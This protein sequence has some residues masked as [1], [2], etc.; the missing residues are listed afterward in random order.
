MPFYAVVQLA[1]GDIIE[2]TR[3]LDGEVP[4]GATVIELPA[5]EDDIRSWLARWRKDRAGG[6]G[7]EVLLDEEEFDVAGGGPPE[8]VRD[9]EAFFARLRQELMR[10]ELEGRTMLVLLFEVAH[11]DRTA[12]RHLVEETMMDAGQEILPCDLLAEIRDYL[13]GVIMPDIDGVG[14]NP[15]PVRGRLRKLT[16]PQD[17][18]ELTALRFRRHPILRR[19]LRRSA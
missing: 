3:D 10:C 14:L 19:L 7:K 11:E 8:G 1:T 13:I 6:G 5:K 12:A 15:I 4:H 16:Y 18:Q 17:K 2:V 9:A